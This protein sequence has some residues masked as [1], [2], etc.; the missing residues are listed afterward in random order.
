MSTTLGL[1]M[2]D[3]GLRP[4]AILTVKPV[5]VD[6]SEMMTL[7]TVDVDWNSV[8][9]EGDKMQLDLDYMS[10]D[11]LQASVAKL[12]ALPSNIVARAKAALIYSPPK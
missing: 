5:A 2:R 3:P 11:D 10:G 4:F 12:Y 9:D 1:M 7:P 8:G 6:I